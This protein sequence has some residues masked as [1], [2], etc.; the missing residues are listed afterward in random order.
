MLHRQ[1]AFTYSTI[2]LDLSMYFF[3]WDVGVAC[4][5]HKWNP[6]TCSHLRVAFPYVPHPHTRLGVQDHAISQSQ[7]L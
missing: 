3:L 2:L 6:R 5:T 4:Y 1:I 7:P